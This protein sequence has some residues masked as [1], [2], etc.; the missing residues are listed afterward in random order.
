MATVQEKDNRIR[1]SGGAITSSERITDNLIY[2]QGILWTGVTAAA[3]KANLIDKDGDLVAALASDAPG[4]SG[5]LMYYLP[6]PNPKG[7]PI[8]GL[9]CDDLDSGELMIYK[10]PV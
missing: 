2:I 7:L 1:I 10:V 9:Y 5:I 4:T 3:H 8:H 6:F